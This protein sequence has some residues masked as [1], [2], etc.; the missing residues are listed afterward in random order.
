MSYK[1]SYGA[2]FKK[3]ENTLNVNQCNK[4]SNCIE[5]YAAKLLV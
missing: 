3:A 1:K 2:F 5:N 4:E